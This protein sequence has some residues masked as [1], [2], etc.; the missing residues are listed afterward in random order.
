MNKNI[1]I[2]VVGV[3]YLGRFHAQK[4]AAMEGVELVGVADADAGRAAQIANECATR[5]YSNYREM[6]PLVDAVSVVVPTS[7]H[8]AIGTICLQAGVDVLMEKPITTTLAQADDLIRLAKA[9]E[10]ILQV[11]HLERFNPAILAARPL[12]RYPVFIESHR[13]AVFKERGTD[14]DVVLDLMIHDIDLVLSIFQSP[15]VSMLATGDQTLTTTNNRASVECTFAS[16]GMAKLTVNRIFTKNLRQMRIL[17]PGEYLLMDF[18]I[19]KVMNVCLQSHRCDTI[20]VQEQDAL[21]LQLLDF[22]QHVRDRTQPAVGGE[23]ARVA[24]DY[25]L[26]IITQIQSKLQESKLQES[27]RQEIEQNP[28]NA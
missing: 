12:V 1:K 7:L 19:K 5:P 9:G 20:A 24:L 18:T 23:E 13:M 27:N 6:L 2:G 25:A 4:Y 21:E 8:H 16:G 28:P 14:V 22:V 11:G 26:Q 15:I 3:G 10:R 17:Q